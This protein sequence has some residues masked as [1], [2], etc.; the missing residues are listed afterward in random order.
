MPSDEYALHLAGALADLTC[1][2]VAPV[3]RDGIVVHQPVA[4]V[5][6]YRRICRPLGGL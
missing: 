5:N 4:T 1:L 3:T 6:L 2:D